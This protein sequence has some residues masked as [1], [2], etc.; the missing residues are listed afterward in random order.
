M[1]R[2]HIPAN[3]VIYEQSREVYHVDEAGAWKI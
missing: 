1:I 3:G 2:S